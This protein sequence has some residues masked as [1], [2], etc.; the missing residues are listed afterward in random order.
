M[1]L[2]W[3]R[4][5]KLFYTLRTTGLSS[6]IRRFSDKTNPRRCMKQLVQ[7][8]R[9]ILQTL[10]A[11]EELMDRKDETFD[12]TTK[13]DIHEFV[14][15]GM[16]F[17]D[18]MHHE[19]EEDI[20]FKAMD[21]LDINFLSTQQGPVK[22]MMRQHNI[23]RSLIDE[24]YDALD[25]ADKMEQV[26]DPVETYIESLRS[27]IEKENNIL[28]PMM[29]QNVSVDDMERISLQFDD[30]N[31][32]NESKTSQLMQ[33]SQRLINKYNPGGDDE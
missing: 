16:Y 12:E 14:D 24:I 29:I 2:L 11:M 31:Q 3:S 13:K 32:D 21:D 20:L 9:T 23:F 27:H 19:K 17:S 4:S 25:T 30:H 18:K 26:M 6:N 15:F 22:E 1:P 10:D 33:I 5:S 28:Y 8:H 7:E